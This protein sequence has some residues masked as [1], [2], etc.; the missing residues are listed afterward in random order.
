ME[1][2]TESPPPDRL[3]V[4]HVVK[5]RM[6]LRLVER[7]CHEVLLRVAHY[8]HQQQGVDSVQIKEKTGTLVINFNSEILSQGRLIGLLQPFGLSQPYQLKESRAGGS[9]TTVNVGQLLS[10]FPPISGLILTRWLRVTG[11]KSIATYIL[12]TGIIRQVIE[13]LTTE[14]EQSASDLQQELT[15]MPKE[16]I[17]ILLAAIET[18]YQIIHQIPGR[19]RLRIDQIRQEP[20]YAQALNQLLKQNPRIKSIRINQNNSSV[21]ITYD[22]AAHEVFYPKGL[23]ESEPLCEAA[24]NISEPNSKVIN[25]FKQE[26]KKTEIS[27]QAAES[28]CLNLSSL[29]TEPS[30]SLSSELESELEEIIAEGNIIDWSVYKANMLSAM[31]QLMSNLP[32]PTT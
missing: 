9:Q 2:N 7:D 10:L 5:G 13:Q 26:E 6:R 30:I 28:D 22:R 19:V 24:R 23:E 27:E 12:T 15:T 16:D 17:S 29:P 1:N 14:E 21:T 18:E 25:I 8:L 4:V 3:E 11:W 32:V 31:L 20:S